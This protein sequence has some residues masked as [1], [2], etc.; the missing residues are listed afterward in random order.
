MD[1][2]ERVCFAPTAEVGALLA[3]TTAD[4]FASD[5]FVWAASLVV[6]EAEVSLL[7]D[8]SR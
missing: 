4:S 2:N 5:D 6:V 8:H 1:A 7:Q 3:V